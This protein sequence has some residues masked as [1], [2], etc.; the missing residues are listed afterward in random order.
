MAG[1]KCFGTMSFQ[2]VLLPR[3]AP[4]SAEP[5]FGTMSFQMVLL[6]TPAAYGVPY[7][8]WNY[9]IPDGSTTR[10]RCRRALQVFWNYVIPDGSTT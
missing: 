7:G 6:P 5:R 10:F 3:V 9:V 4:I 1:S 2:M 8:F